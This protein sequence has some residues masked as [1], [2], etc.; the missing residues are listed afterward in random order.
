MDP[1]LLSS[2]TEPLWKDLNAKIMGNVAKILSVAWENVKWDTAEDE[3]LRRIVK[4]LS[5]TRLLGNPKPIIIDALYTDVYL[6]DTPSAKRTYSTSAI[7]KLSYEDLI[8]SDVKKKSSAL[9]IQ[10]TNALLYILGKPG[11][12]K[13]TFLKYLAIQ[14]ANRNI[15]KTPVFIPLKEWADSKLDLMR[16]LEKQFDIC[17]FPEAKLVIETLLDQGKMLLLFDGLDEVTQVEQKRRNLIAEILHITQKYPK[18][19][20]CVTCRTAADDYTFEHFTYAEI[21]DFDNKQ[22][23]EFAQKWYND[24]DEKYQIFINEWNRSRNRGLRDLATTPLLLALLCLAFDETLRFPLRRVDL[25]KEAIDALL[26]R[27]DSSRDILRDIPYKE[28][29]PT[30]KEQLLSRL[31]AE[32]F[33]KKHYAFRPHGVESHIEK[34]L[35]S[36]PTPE[37]HVEIHIGSIL[38]SIEAQ[39]GLIVERAKEIYSF[40][41]LTFH[42]YFTARYIVENVDKGTITRLVRPEIIADHRWHEVVLLTASLLHS[43]DRFFDRF[44]KCI[45]DYVISTVHLRNFLQEVNILASQ[46]QL[47]DKLAGLQHK[48]IKAGNSQSRVILD[49]IS[50]LSSNTS[51]FG[52]MPLRRAYTLLAISEGVI[53]TQMQHSTEAIGLYKYCRMNQLMTECLCVASVNNRSALEHSLLSPP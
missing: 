11:S 2:A 19:S 38:R 12:G 9:K 15:A 7:E 52:K 10:R 22:K 39:H 3:Y 20:V 36:L 4:N 37:V 23:V 46:P 17:H 6:L 42:E 45:G 43:A 31:A 41:H 40:S 30:R 18:N 51:K 32:T 29:S 5:T 28:L 33:Q 13:T 53:C 47:K 27:W 50:I 26:R 34:F 25:Y 48:K 35:K 8:S 16:F 24:N 21:A 14:A 1:T 49:M 44:V